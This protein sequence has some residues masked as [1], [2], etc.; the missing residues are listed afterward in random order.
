MLQTGFWAPSVN[1][2]GSTGTR[3]PQDLRL[4]GQLQLQDN[5]L[6][7]QKD[8]AAQDQGFTGQ[9]NALS[10]AL[11]EAMQGRSLG[12]QGEQAGLDRTQAK[13]LQS[14]ALANQLNIARMP[15]DFARE[16]FNSVF[17]M[18]SGM[19]GGGGSLSA[20]TGAVGPASVAQRG[21]GTV[22][23]SG[24]IDQSVNAMKAGNAQGAA[25]QQ[26]QNATQNAA[27]GFG[28]NSPLLQALNNQ[29][30]MGAMQANTTGERETRL[31]AATANAKQGLAA[32]T[33]N[34]QARAA[35]EQN[36]IDARRTDVNARTSL[37]QALAGML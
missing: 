27:G 28:A 17:P 22:Y 10:R 15:V 9:Q 35:F 29:V 33:A 12:F 4:K 18:V 14:S 25:T 16:K 5:Q 24:Q 37:L 21:P 8:L 31:G 32:S 6:Q 3:P 7:G 30:A 20:S 13:D 2:Y 34:N 19:L 23:N 26:R 1:D 11:Q 36:A